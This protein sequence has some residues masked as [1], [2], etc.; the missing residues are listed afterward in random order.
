MIFHN[1]S[2]SEQEIPL[3]DIL[4]VRG[5]DGVSGYHVPWLHLPPNN[6]DFAGIGLLHRP[7]GTVQM[8]L[9]ITSELSPVIWGH[10]Y[11]DEYGY[12]ID[13]CKPKAC[14]ELRPLQMSLLRVRRVELSHVWDFDE[15]PRP[16]LLTTGGAE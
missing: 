3:I 1:V 12:H 13:V 14:F 10:F 16:F 2:S 5:C 11:E 9:G 4:R 15:D 6:G 8:R 7:G